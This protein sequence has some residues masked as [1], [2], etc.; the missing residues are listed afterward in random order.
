MTWKKTFSVNNGKFKLEKIWFEIL[1]KYFITIFLITYV[2]QAQYALL[3]YYYLFY[4]LS[5]IEAP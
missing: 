1:L 4:Y 2:K 5:E 3:S